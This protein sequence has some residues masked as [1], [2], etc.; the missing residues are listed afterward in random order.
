MSSDEQRHV[1][2]PKLYG[3]PA[4]AR[5]SVPHA[6]I[7][8]PFDPDELPLANAMSEEDVEVLERETADREEPGPAP[9]PELAARPFSIRAIVDRLGARRG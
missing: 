1:A 9:E 8:R 2:L 4:Y 3:A 7:E 6:R 5:P